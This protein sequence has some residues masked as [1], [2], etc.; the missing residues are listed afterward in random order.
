MTLDDATRDQIEAARPDASTWLGANAGSGKT[1]VLTDRVARLLL[2]G[3]EPQ[4]ILCLTYTKAAASE[5]QNRLFK[6]LGEWAMLRDTDLRAAMSELGVAGALDAA[7]LRKAR[8]L[9]ALAIETPGG[10]KIQTIHSFCASLLRRFPLEAGVSPQFSE[11]EDRAADLLRADIVDAMSEGPQADLIS[12]IARFYT[13][14]DFGKLTRRIVGM[15][16]GFEKQV[17]RSDILGHLGQ[18]GELDADMVEAGVFLGGEAELIAGIVPHLLAKGGNDAKA[19]AKL[20]EINTV[21]LAILPVLESVFLTSSSAKSP[22]TAKIGSFPT[23]ATQAV[24]GASMHQLEALMLRVEDTRNARLSLLAAEKAEA[25]HQFAHAFLQRYEN[26]KQLR[27]W[28]DFDDLILRARALLQDERVAAWVLYR[29]DGGI[30]HIL[31]DEA[32]DTSPRQ[33]DIIELLADEFYSGSGARADTER[34]L[35]VVGDKKQSI[36][37][38]QGADP[39]E[40]DRKSN[41]FEAK[42]QTAGQIFQRRSLD[43]SFRSSSAI[44]RFVDTVFDPRR[45]MGLDANSQHIAFKETLPG[46]VDLWPVIAKAEPDED[47]PWT[48]PLD[49]RS[50]Q[51]HTVI[52]AE[53]IAAKI[54]ELTNPDNPSFIPDDGKTRGSLI[55]RPIRAGDFLILVQRRSALFAE[56]IRACKAAGLPIAGA[57]RLKVGAELA[58]KDLAALLSFLATPDDNLSLATALKSPLFGWAEQDL[59]DLAHKRTASSLTQALRS[60]SEEFSE[61]LSVLNDLRG[62]VDFLRPYDLIER[63]LTRHGGREKLLARLGP[64]AEDGINAMLTQALAYERNDIPSLTGFIQWMQTDDL[65][66]KRQIDS[67]SNQIRVMTVHGSKGLEAP[68]VILPDTGRRDVVIKDEIV[69]MNAVPVWKPSADALPEAMRVTIEE[70]KEAQY[71]ERLRLLYV[72]M[73]RAEKWLMIAAAGDLSKDKTDWYQ[74]AGEAMGHVNAVDLNGSGIRRFE[75]GDWDD[76]EVEIRPESITE[77]PALEPIF[78]KT[79]PV[80]SHEKEI[81]SPSDL[82]GKKALAGTDGE[83]SE[84]AMAYGTLVHSLLETLPGLEE[85]AFSNAARHLTLNAAP[86]DADRAVAEVR[87]ILDTPALAPVFAPETLTEVPITAPLGGERLHGII[88]RL[89]IEQDRILLVDYKTNRTVPDTAAACPDG[90]LRQMGA[91]AMMLAQLFPNKRI[92]T[93]ILWTAPARLMPLPH[94]LVT[95]AVAQSPYLDGAHVHS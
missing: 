7:Q 36:Y 25:L 80:F 5:M 57:D 34:T 91:Y 63:V 47:R 43:Y 64:E 77:T 66:I 32:Q 44:L 18:P 6:R 39:L 78:S 9:F 42:I 8:T 20:Q 45:Q 76:L 75:E 84:Q 54:K 71:A 14:E 28:L 51:H 12:N 92:E 37:S 26:A 93:A 3:V 67:A 4:H 17:T 22:F 86:E 61:T 15:R 87:R 62:Q 59:F 19:G 81:F 35:F 69:E 89:I 10:L 90:I 33:W 2:N 48:D 41:A 46:R 13:G 23:K 50:Q 88:D 58:V 70:M 85:P 49:R 52:L 29:I 73:T 31:V 65:E 1:R 53:Q 68:I 24:L 11:I 79:L 60:R 83:E 27:G 74:I 55:R 56:I 72:A 16:D 21:N 95:S 94:D 40:F 82:G 30:D 38:F